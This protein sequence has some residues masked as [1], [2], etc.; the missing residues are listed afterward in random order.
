VAATVA[1]PL[2]TPEGDLHQLAERILSDNLSFGGDPSPP[3]PPLPSVVAS[4][5]IALAGSSD[6]W[7]APPPDPSEQPEISTQNEAV[8]A[9]DEQSNGHVEMREHVSLELPQSSLASAR[10]VALLVQLEDSEHNVV[11]N[12]ERR[13][14]ISTDS[15]ELGKLLFDL[16]LTVTPQR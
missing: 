11:G 12:L 6:N 3:P 1:Q 5:D 4:A 16:R 10:R 13:F 8:A 9:P 7:D 15:S 2:P 14:D